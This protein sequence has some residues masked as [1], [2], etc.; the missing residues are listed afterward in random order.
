MVE[1]D[2]RPG[3]S[4]EATQIYQFSR[5]AAHIDPQRRVSRG[6]NEVLASEAS[7]TRLNDDAAHA[8]Q[9]GT[10]TMLDGVF[11]RG[12]VRSTKDVPFGTDR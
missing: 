2:P 10:T 8:V 3:G 7:E 4:H 6:E 1:Y 11:K 9:F 12:H 5:R